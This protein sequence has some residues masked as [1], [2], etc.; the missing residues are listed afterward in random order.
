MGRAILVEE[1]VTVGRKELGWCTNR[2]TRCWQTSHQAEWRYRPDCGKPVD[3][4]RSLWHSNGEA[5]VKQGTSF[6]WWWL[7]KYN[8][9]SLKKFSR[10]GLVRGLG[11][12]SNLV[13]HIV[14]APIAAAMFTISL[15]FTLAQDCLRFWINK[16]FFRSTRENSNP[17]FPTYGFSLCVPVFSTVSGLQ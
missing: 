6:S 1:R 15:K 10:A 3:A 12:D 14:F 5:F 13:G 4:S 7:E 8:H 17:R 9:L 11:I 16:E 2:E